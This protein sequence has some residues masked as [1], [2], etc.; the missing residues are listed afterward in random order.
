MV[1]FTPSRNYPYSQS[2]DPADVAGDTQRLAEAID[3]DVET[4]YGTVL[5]RRTARIR[6]LA[7]VRQFFPASTQTE[8]TFDFIDVDNAG[9]VDLGAFPTRLT[10]TSAGLWAFWGAIEVPNAFANAFEFLLR[11]NG[12]ESTRF[13]PHDN[14][15]GNNTVMRTIAGVAT[16]NGTTDHFT[17]SFNPIAATSEFRISNKHF[18]CFRLTN[19]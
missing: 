14:D 11:K 3:P 6:S 17:L 19:T 5:P 7:A 13:T 1:A 4:V 8:L 18:G 9:I 10:P 12:A 16:A 15:P 2:T